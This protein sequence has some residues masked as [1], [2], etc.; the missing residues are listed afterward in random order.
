MKL[1]LKLFVGI[2]VCF[3]LTAPAFAELETSAGITFRLR[4]ETWDDLF[5]F[6]AIDNV[7]GNA[8]Q[9]ND[10]NFWRLKTTPWF[11][12]DVNK[13]YTGYVRLANEA[14]Y[15]MDTNNRNTGQLGFNKDELLFDNLVVKAAGLAGMADLT[16][17]R[18]DFLGAFG[19]GFLIVDGTPLDGSRTFYFDAA[20]ALVKLGQSW[21]VDLVYI[22]NHSRD[23]RLPVAHSAPQR[24]LNP[25]DENGVVVYGRGKVSE[26]LIIEPYYIWKHEAPFAL[27]FIPAVQTS[28]LRDDLRLHTLGVRAVLGFGGGWKLRG[29]VASQ[30]GEYFG[31]GSMDRE[32]LG[33]YAFIGRKYETVPLKPAFDLGYVMLSG[34]DPNT[35]NKVEAWNPLWSRYPWMSE[36][37]SL[38]Y[39]T[40][41][42]VPAYWTNL[43][44][45]RLAFKFA[46]PTDSGLEL[47]YS[48]LDADENYGGTNPVFSRTG[49]DR[50]DLIIVKLSRQFSKTVAGYVTV[51]EFLPGDFYAA[52]NRDNATFVRWELTWKI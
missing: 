21:N 15:Y 7:A 1:L 51:E 19:E 9:S 33:G 31:T 27:T 35:L 10:T 12:L 34:D 39:A 38:S 45:W 5:D 22:D 44:M 43:K 28:A 6:R 20:R 18:Q 3:V 40:E 48:I 29:E 16:Y 17:G 30:S 13:K 49:K 23:D 24:A 8:D 37:Y 50:G 26:N 14:R 4:Q 36:L 32:G 42:G 52:T 11:K 47:S 41:T 46:L 25:S 2:A